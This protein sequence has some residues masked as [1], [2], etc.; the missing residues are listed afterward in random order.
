MIN[1]IK[2]FFPESFY[3]RLTLFALVGVL[4]GSAFYNKLIEYTIYYYCANDGIRLPIEG[5]ELLIP[6]VSFVNIFISLISGVIFSLIIVLVK[7]L[8][9]YALLNIKFIY[10]LGVKFI[11][12]F[13]LNNFLNIGENSESESI[14][15]RKDIKESANKK[16]LLL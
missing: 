4:T 14:D 12:I 3:A 7:L 6:V 8:V 9:E 2:N 10:K 1:T 16:I 15:F 13:R 5:I 11:S